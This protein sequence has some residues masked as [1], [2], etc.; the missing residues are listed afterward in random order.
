MN[1]PAALFTGVNWP[2]LVFSHSPLPLPGIYISP[3]PFILP[4]YLVT[5]LPSLCEIFTGVNWPE[6]VFRQSPVPIPGIYLLTHLFYLVTLLPCYLVTWSLWNFHGSKLAVACSS[7]VTCTHTWYISPHPFIL[8]RYLVTLLPCY[9]FFV[10]INVA[11]SLLDDDMNWVKQCN[12]GVW[13]VTC[14]GRLFN[15]H[16]AYSG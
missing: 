3:H 8:P 10:R 5:L 1:Q 16:I 14:V 2:E 11:N 15:M 7:P 9:L 6:L 12:V 13:Q 4:R